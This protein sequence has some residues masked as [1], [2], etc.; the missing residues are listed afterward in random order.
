MRAA[1]RRVG[2]HLHRRVGYRGAFTVDGVM[3]TDGFRPTE[4]NPRFG[5]GINMLAPAVDLPLYLLHLAVIADPG[6]SWVPERFEGLVVGAA[7]RTRAAR[8]IVLV[9]DA[10]AESEVRLRRDG[11]ALV[12]LVAPTDGGHPA[13]PERPADVT[14]VTGDA[15][16]GSAIRVVVDAARVPAGRS[17]APLMAS[18]LAWADARWN[19]GLGPLEA[20]PDMST[21]AEP[22]VT[23]GRQAAAE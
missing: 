22:T 17:V 6:A 13:A 2:D 21:T 20:A 9:P 14:L 5:A 10:I 16:V 3:T 15:P 1:A 18:A 23:T 11:D 8:G 7:D 4:L 19:L 12:E